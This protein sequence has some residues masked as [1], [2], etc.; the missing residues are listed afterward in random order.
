[1][2]LLGLSDEQ[3]FPALNGKHPLLASHLEH[4][5]GR[6]DDVDAFSSIVQRGHAC[7]A[8]AGRST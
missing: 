6:I 2:P 8:V 4:L 7:V 3:L 1:M 5:A